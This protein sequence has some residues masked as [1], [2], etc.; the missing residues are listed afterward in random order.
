[1]KLWP[2]HQQESKV[3][4]QHDWKVIDIQWL[5]KRNSFYGTVSPLMIYKDDQMVTRYFYGCEGCEEIWHRDTDGFLPGG[6]P[7]EL[8]MTAK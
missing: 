1:M 7:I 8:R 2:F 3:K 5:F 4:H 6:H